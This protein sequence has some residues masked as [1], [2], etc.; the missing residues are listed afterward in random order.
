VGHLVETV[1]PGHPVGPLFD[2]WAFNLDGAPAEPADE[3]MV[4]AV[5][6]AA[7]VQGLAVIASERIQLPAVGE[8]TELVV[9][10]RQGDVL[11]AGLKLCV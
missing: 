7:P 9:D 2:F 4:V 5:G 1:Q 3:V 10:G 6:R 8:S 11:A